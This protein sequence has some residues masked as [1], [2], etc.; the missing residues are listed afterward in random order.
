MDPCR[1][2]VFSDQEKVLYEAVAR[3]DQAVVVPLDTR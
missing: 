3:R 2:A 1:Y